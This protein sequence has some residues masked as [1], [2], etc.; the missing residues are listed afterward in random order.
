MPVR[1]SLFV[2]LLLSAFHFCV[3]QK[4]SGDLLE[5]KRKEFDLNNYYITLNLQNALVLTS[6]VLEWKFDSLIRSEGS[7]HIR[8]NLVKLKYNL[9]SVITKTTL[10][11]DP[12]VG[13]LDSWALAHQLVNYFSN[14][15]QDALCGSNRAVIL[16]LMDRYLD[17]Y[18]RGLSPYVSEQNRQQVASFA[19][20]NPI[21]DERLNRRSIVPQLA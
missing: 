21:L 6:G 10:H 18:A 13:A 12:L 20:R 7:S 8:S 14:P 2:W 19:E 17:A 11:S 15:L 5:S 16:H 4:R 3:G 9:I 1:S